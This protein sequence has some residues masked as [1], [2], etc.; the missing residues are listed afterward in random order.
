MGAVEQFTAD[1]QLEQLAFY[2]MNVDE[3]KMT[4]LTIRV[5]SRQRDVYLDL[6][7][8]IVSR[9]S[10]NAR[11]ARSMNSAPPASASSRAMLVH[12]GTATAAISS[13]PC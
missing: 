11:P 3:G 4:P 2:W 6:A 9:K 7:A 1:E 13:R 8:Q 10:A 12:F 5:L